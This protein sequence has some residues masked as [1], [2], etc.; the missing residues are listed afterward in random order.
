MN[1][2]RIRSW[3]L[4]DVLLILVLAVGLTA[5]PARNAKT[6]STSAT[7]GQGYAWYQ[8]AR[9]VLVGEGAFLKRAQENHEQ[10]CQSA[11]TLPSI[12]D[13][14]FCVK[15][16]N[17]VNVAIAQHRM[18]K[19]ALDV[20]CDGPGWFEGT[21]PCRPQSAHEV[22][23]KAAYLAFTKSLE[24]FTVKTAEAPKK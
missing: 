5:C 16:C 9:D 14:A 17:S 20:F 12:K 13:P 19:Q 21:A 10:D 23:A 15:L 4:M 6:N 18:S 7:P 1:R 2:I 22:A 11:C 24:L 8:V 3:F